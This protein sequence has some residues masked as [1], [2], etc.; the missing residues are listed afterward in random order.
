ML[1]LC[2]AADSAVT[3][4]ENGRVERTLEGR[5]ARCVAVD[6]RDPNTLYVG[7]SD[8]GLFKSEDGGRSW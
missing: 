6:P 2:A 3:I 5:G 7:T 8:E 1:R 4:V